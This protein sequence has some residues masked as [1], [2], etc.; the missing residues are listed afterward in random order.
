MKSIGTRIFR[1]ADIPSSNSYL[2]QN[3][4]TYEQGDVLIAKR[5]SA[6]RGRYGRAWISEEGGL[7]MSILLKALPNP[8]DVLPFT[9]LSALAVVRVLKKY[10]DDN[11][12]VKWPNDVYVRDRKI[13]GILCEA[14][15]LAGKTNA[16]I[17]IGINVNNELISA[18]TLPHSAINLR[19]LRGEHSDINLLAENLLSEIRQIFTE[20]KEKGFTVFQSQLNEVLYRRG[21]EMDLQIQGAR[22]EIIIPLAYC[23]DST[24]L[25]LR[26][27]KEE[28]LYIGELRANSE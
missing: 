27:G 26:Q 15:V 4:D 18:S 7:Y 5:Q 17:G 10:S 16:V 12:A 19:E 3:A 13:C 14:R 23:E 21:K 1:I 20:Y 9:P 11:F 22:K 24:L 28:K 25:C 6:G 2:L 8:A